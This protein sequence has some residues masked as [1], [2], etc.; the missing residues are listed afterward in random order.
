MTTLEKEVRTILKIWNFLKD[1]KEKVVIVY[2]GAGSGKS[3]TVAQYIIF[4]LCL[5]KKNKHILITRKTNPALRLT[6][7]RLVK[8]ILEQ[9]RDTIPYEE[10]VSEQIIRFPLTG[11]TIFFRGID[12]P[13]KLKSSEF[14]YIWME[15]A[16]EFTFEDYQ[17]LRLRLRRATAGDRNQMF[18]TFNPVASWI[19]EYFFEQRKEKDTAILKTTYVDNPYLTDDYREQL[20]GLEKQDKAYY[21]IYTLG[22]FA[23]LEHI[24]FTNYTIEDK[25][26]ENYDEIIYGLDFGYN[27]PTALLEIGIKDDEIYILRELYETK[28]TNTELI[29]RMK[30]FVRFTDAEIYCDSAEPQ[31]IEEIRQA[32]FN[33][34]PSTKEVK[35]GI[36]FVK[37]FPLHINS[38]CVNTI[39]EIRAYRW[40]EDRNG[41]IIDEPVK[42]TDHTM[43]A[44][45]YAIVTHLRYL[46]TKVLPKTSWG[47]F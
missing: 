16:T 21:Q 33:A 41:N 13:E 38:N 32:G 5:L 4:N 35:Y 31:R 17:Q 42:F 12:N 26:P 36:D 1:S 43:D 7:Y 20:L 9:M 8:S 3:Y 22:E 29:E 37:K 39:K 18:L 30:D 6:A 15:E 27:N 28:L 11:S 10:Q 14:N 46:E 2:G 45:R 34:Y 47:V 19:Q 23:V 40:K 24:I 25:M 44:M